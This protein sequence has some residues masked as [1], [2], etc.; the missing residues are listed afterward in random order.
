MSDRDPFADALTESGVNVDDA[1]DD[2][3]EF[4]RALKESGVELEPLGSQPSGTMGTGNRGLDALLQWYTGMAEAA[5]L[6]HAGEAGAIGSKLGTLLADATLPSLERDGMAPEYVG[7][8][9]VN[10]DE[11]VQRSMDSGLGKAGYVTG[12]VAPA[13]ASGGAT[14]AGIAPRAAVGAVQG[15]AGAHGNTPDDPLAVL[16]GGAAG[17]ALGAA[18]AAAGQY[19]GTPKWIDAG[20]KGAQ[21]LG[22]RGEELLMGLADQAK[23][24]GGQMI[25]GGV[26]GGMLAGYQDPSKAIGGAIKGAAAAGALGVAGGQLPRLAPYLPGAAAMAG[27]AAAPVGGQVAGALGASSAQAQEKAYGTA[28]TMAWAVQSVLA[29]GNTGLAPMDEQRLTEAVLSGDDDRV[30]SANFTLQ[31]KYPAYAAR[32]QRELESLQEE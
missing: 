15:A 5:S 18:G 27:T 16:A 17:G 10:A 4:G 12:L 14:A 32:L 3:D 25:G 7:E 20:K 23:R 22:T 9:G 28:P 26:L 31:Q 30:I 19:L 29:G 11:L 21:M 1:E 24:V 6:N 13:I 8:R 2:G